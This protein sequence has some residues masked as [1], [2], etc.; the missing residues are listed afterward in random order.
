MSNSLLMTLVR[1]HP[2]LG[3]LPLL[4][5]VAGLAGCGEKTS[6]APA[7]GSG[8]I[9]CND[10]TGALDCCE[11]STGQDSCSQKVSCFNTCRFASE[12]VEDG[13]RS[14]AVCVDGKWQRGLGLFPCT[15]NLGVVDRDAGTSGAM[16]RPAD[17][18]GPRTSLSFVP[19]D[20][21]TNASS[22]GLGVSVSSF[23][24]S[25]STPAQSLSELA[26]VLELV[27]WPSAEHV[28]SAVSYDA[29]AGVYTTQVRLAPDAALAE[30]WY[31]LRL[32]PPP[33]VTSPAYVGSAVIDG[34]PTS[35][36][37]VGSRP[38]LKRIELCEKA[39]AKSKL[40]VTFSEALSATNDVAS[41]VVVTSSG[42]T[43]SCDL[44][45]VTNRADYA[46]LELLCPAIASTAS[47][48]IQFE[49]LVS[50]SGAPLRTA[51]GASP[52]YTIDVAS[53]REAAGCRL[54]QPPPAPAP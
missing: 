27:R 14:Q 40:R 7:A 23:P 9:A 5:V 12:S 44:I 10:A 30:G 34:L 38:L 19:D 36:F 50:T 42:A 21:T 16:S 11:E 45:E 8:R 47:L 31:A 29:D 15:R 39:G 33:A 17:S 24:V 13:L 26:A 3:F 51:A 49:G 20:Q 4:F 6:P 53:L 1:P 52:D 28:P 48:R 41:A 37:H 35:R 43:L 54:F 32:N 22:S 25:S 18:G 46:G 2:L